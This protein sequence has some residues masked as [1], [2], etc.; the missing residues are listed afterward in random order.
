MDHWSKH[1]SW[2]N[3]ASRRKHRRTLCYLGIGKYFL[4]QIKQ[5]ISLKFRKI[6][7]TPLRKFIGKPQT[8]R[9]ICEAKTYLT[10]K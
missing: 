8:R 9:Y 4:G 1:K 10:K 7:R 2:N 6:K 3:E 5:L